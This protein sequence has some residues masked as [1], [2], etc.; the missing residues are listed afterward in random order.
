MVLCYS[1]RTDSDTLGPLLG[2]AE[3]EP[4]P[5]RSLEYSRGELSHRE[6]PPS[7][8]RSILSPAHSRF[9]GEGW[10][11]LSTQQRLAF[12]I[13]SLVK[14]S[15]S[16]FRYSILPCPHSRMGGE[17]GRSHLEEV[18]SPFLFRLQL[19]RVPHSHPGHLG[20]YVIFTGLAQNTACHGLTP[21]WRVLLPSG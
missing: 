16:A 6:T 18:P 2:K 9:W 7:W 17:G 13:Q 19:L 3:A 21:S 20:L 8:P 10:L 15:V 4:A 5:L 12:S 11:S 14:P 1:S